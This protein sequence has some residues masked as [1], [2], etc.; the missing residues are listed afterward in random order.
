MGRD[1]IEERYGRLYYIPVELAARGHQVH[2]LC[3]DYPWAAEVH[4]GPREDGVSWHCCAFPLGGLTFKRR[5]GRLA[6]T[7]KADLILGMADSIY[8]IWARAVARELGCLFAFDLYDNFETFANMRWPWV[9]AGYRRALREARVVS[10]VSDRLRDYIRETYSPSGQV[11]SVPSVV[12]TE[13]FRPLDKQRCRAELGLRCGVPLVGYFGA[14]DHNRGINDLFQGW[15]LIRKHRPDAQLILAGKVGR[16]VVLPGQDQ[17]VRYLGLL[18]HRQMPACINACDVVTI[19]NVDSPFGRFCFPQKLCEYMA[20][21]VP[22]VATGLGAV[23]D[24]LR[25]WKRCTYPPGQPDLFAARTLGFL[26]K[27]EIDY[28]TVPAWTDVV[29]ALDEAFRQAVAGST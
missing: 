5:A 26:E 8:G 16:K 9:P 25:P 23:S 28:G 29:T 14:L 11:L 4:R 21:G 27:P 2:V 15:N 17:R 6:R 18:P 12:D 22:V 19:F 1:L 13:R 20:C 10:C 24:F 3:L 7:V